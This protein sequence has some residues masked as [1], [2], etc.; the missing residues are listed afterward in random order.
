MGEPARKGGRGRAEP[1]EIFACPN[2]PFLVRGNI[3]LDV[4]DAEN[5]GDEAR[6]GERRV[7]ALCRCG[8][9]SIRPYCDGIH[10]VIGFRTVP[11]AR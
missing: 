7:V 8:A 4:D 10:K 5:P 3:A 9:S 6:R 11:P 2:G 1:V